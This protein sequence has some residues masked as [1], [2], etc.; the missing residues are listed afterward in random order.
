MIIPMMSLKDHI[1]EAKNKGVAIG[2][3]NISTID[4][5]WAVADTA[6]ALKVPVIIGVSEGERD[7]FGV[8]EIAAVVR[9]I[10]QER[11]Q[12]IFVNADHTYS[13]D[14]VKEAIDAGFDAVIFDGAK[15]P[16]EENIK[17]AKQCVEYTRSN[18]YTLHPTPYT[19]VEGELGYIGQSSE[20]MA[21]KPEGVQLTSP[22]D[23]KRF[24][25]ETGV[26][27]LAPAV[28]N[29]HGLLEGDRELTLEA[30]KIDPKRVKE[31]SD[32]TGLPLVLHGG[33]GQGDD[34]VR[35]AI[36]AGVAIVH[37]NTELRVAYRAGLIRSLSDNADEVAP[38]KYM[39]P[40][41]LAMAKVV[42]EKLRLFN[43]F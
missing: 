18:P 25:I 6:Q 40:A 27:L 12:P 34:L 13:F 2:H 31:I 1:D 28:G 15:L 7:Y 4:G 38:Y 35:K 22:E 3:F 17:I 8:G 24:T 39:K 20:V 19:I 9:Q 36:K 5:V 29:F 37:V 30:K 10:R 14:K 26:D 23:A 11:D 43:G 21:S 42:E 33:S 32:T 16:L 41:K